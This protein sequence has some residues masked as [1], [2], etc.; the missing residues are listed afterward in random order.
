MKPKNFI[1]NLKNGFFQIL[2]KFRG[3]FVKKPNRKLTWTVEDYELAKKWSKSQKHPY[4]K[5]KTLW[6]YCEDRY[7]SVYTIQNVNNF[8]NV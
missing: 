8:I 3:L 4:L 1:Y 6:D 5:L 2:L 7:E